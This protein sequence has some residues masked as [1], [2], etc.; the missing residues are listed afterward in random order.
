MKKILIG[1]ILVVVALVIFFGFRG[2]EKVSTNEDAEGLINREEQDAL[3]VEARRLNEGK[4]QQARSVQEQESD[5][6]KEN[7]EK[8]VQDGKKRPSTEEMFHM[9]KAEKIAVDEASSAREEAR[10]AWLKNECVRI[11]G[12]GEEAKMCYFRGKL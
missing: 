7:Q 1:I 3:M 6:L 2:K 12:E 9:T 4:A 10:R 11:Y 8:Y 5:L